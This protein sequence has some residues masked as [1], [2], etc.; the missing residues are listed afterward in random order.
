[1]LNLLRCLDVVV[2]K[3]SEGGFGSV[4]SCFNV[5]RIY[6]DLHAIKRIKSTDSINSGDRE[7]RF[8][9]VSK[10]NSKYLIKY[11]EAFTVDNDLYVVMEYFKNGNLNDFIKRHREAGQKIKENVYFYFIL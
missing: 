3:I 8:G 4:Y 5:K 6:E 2:N 9:H 10:L 1:L 11:P 7:R